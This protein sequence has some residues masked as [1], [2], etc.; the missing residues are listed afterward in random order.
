MTITVL[1]INHLPLL[2]TFCAECNKL[3]WKNNRSIS[4]MKF[5][6]VYSNGGAYLGIIEHNT[7]ISVAGYTTFPEIHA[8]AYKIFYRS[9]TLPG[10]VVNTGL[11]RGTGP[12]GRMYID[13]FIKLCPSEELYV[14]TNIENTSYRNILRYNRS[15][16]LE[17]K[18]PDAYIHKV[19]EM[20]LFNTLQ[21]VWKLDIPAY[22]KRTQNDNV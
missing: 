9:A 18:L 13:S 10:K 19:C 14:T 3:G 12:R 7:L 1:T 15:L 22:K 8:G 6:E 5:D 11:H 16:E 2:A 17:S 20:T 21:A 4:E